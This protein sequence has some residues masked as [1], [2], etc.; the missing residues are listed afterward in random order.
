MNKLEKT[1]QSTLNQ[2]QQT[3]S[4]KFESKTVGPLYLPQGLLV[5]RMPITERVV[6]FVNFTRICKIHK[7]IRYTELGQICQNSLEKI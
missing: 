5:K 3:K 4:S 2:E 6:R 1:E 7:T